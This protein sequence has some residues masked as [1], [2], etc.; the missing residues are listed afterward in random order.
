[1][2][3]INLQ[4][5]L[6]DLRYDSVAPYIQKNID[7]PGTPSS[8]PVQARVEDLV[9][10]SKY[11]VDKG[12]VFVA[13][14]AMLEA[15]KANNLR[16]VFTL[17]TVANP[18][19]RIGNMLAQIP[20]NGT[21]THFVAIGGGP[22][23]GF[24][25]RNADAAAEAKYGGRVTLSQPDNRSVLK[26]SPQLTAPAQ[27]DYQRP[28]TEAGN[29]AIFRKGKIKKPVTV[30]I[31]NT[32][33]SD[34][35]DNVFAFAG[36]GT[37][38][39][40]NLLDIGQGDPT[41]DFVPVIF[42]LFGDASSRLLFRGYIQNLTD[43]FNG[44]WSPVNYVGRMEQFFT[45]TGFT[46]TIGFQLVVPIFSQAEQPIVYNKVNSLVSY[47]APKYLPGSNIPQ[48]NIVS[49]TLGNYIKTN[50]ILTSVGNSIANDVPWSYSAEGEYLAGETRLLPQVLTLSIAYTPIHT[51]TPQL[52]TT[53]HT[54]GAS[55]T[56]YI[57]NSV[58]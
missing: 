18:V 22:S 19:L 16:D 24:Y 4:T 28:Q 9:R 40:V 21:G 29:E 57:N 31:K 13:K 2:P 6:K 47:T 32:S 10:I 58:K 41:D 26:N 54:R 46:R 39:S 48:G 15:S 49:L 17:G 33:I 30:R 36:T 56:P 42:K 43:N 1:M 12:G 51:K 45:Y 50:G 38:D 23:G 34:S 37:S 7:N 5:T 20:V 14:Q 53:A 3:L 8:N 25:T 11:L 44:N 27:L 55:N 52:Y 35:L